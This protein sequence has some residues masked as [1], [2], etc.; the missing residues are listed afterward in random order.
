MLVVSG[1]V[2]FAAPPPFVPPAPAGATIDAD[3]GCEP[4]VGARLPEFEESPLIPPPEFLW[5]SLTPTTVATTTTMIKMNA[6]TI[7]QSFFD[8]CFV[9]GGRVAAVAICLPRPWLESLAV[10]FPPGGTVPGRGDGRDDEFPCS[11]RSGL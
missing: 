11:N 9:A 3:V 4:S 6:A 5:D 1:F 2:P 7:N 10:Y 8:R